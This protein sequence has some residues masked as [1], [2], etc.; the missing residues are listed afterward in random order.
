MSL[1]NVRKQQQRNLLAESEDTMADEKILFHL[2]V[3]PHIHA[4]HTTGSIM[5][6]VLLALTPA[7]IFSVFYFGI[8]VLLVYA[9]C[10]GS[11]VLAEY[12]WQKCT[13]QKV[14]IKDCSAL[15]TGMLLAMNLPASIPL[16]MAAIGSIFAII[17]VK[18]IFGGIG[19]NFMNPALAARCFMLVAW[20]S[21]MTNF[22]VQG[23]S[24][25]TPMTIIKTGGELPSLLNTFLGTVSGSLGE[26]SA[27]LLLI[28]G[29]YLIVRG[30]IDWTLP[31]TYIAVVLV[32]SYAFGHDGL[33]EVLSGGL[34][35][36]A[37]FMATDYTT[38]PMTRKGRIIM[39]IGCGLLTALIR[40]FGGYPE[41]VSFSILLMNICVPLIDRI[42]MPKIYGEVKS[43]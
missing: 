40:T 36:V 18:Q 28:G 7:A 15:V 34:M 24:T 23:V 38:S 41:G 39:G 22:T 12:V 13:K 9:V 26:T 35:L 1:N 19:Q 27:I 16:W 31:V 2:S 29:I 3:S 21:A 6:E 25:A 5:C 10:M 8:R 30:I 33:Y 11:S 43:K 37:F 32:L 14:T 17:I 20:A 4:K 42:S